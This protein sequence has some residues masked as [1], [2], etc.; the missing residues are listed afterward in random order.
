MGLAA[1]EPHSQR[2]HTGIRKI[3]KFGINWASF[4]WDI[5]I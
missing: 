1:I 2:E 5:D 3:P 4:D